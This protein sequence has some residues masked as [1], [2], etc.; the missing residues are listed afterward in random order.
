MVDSKHEGLVNDAFPS[1]VRVGL[2]QV[3]KCVRIGQPKDL[4]M[5]A[6]AFE[7]WMFSTHDKR[8]AIESPD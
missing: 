7:L 4:Y 6:E 2:I 8:V 3:D 1:F 5:K